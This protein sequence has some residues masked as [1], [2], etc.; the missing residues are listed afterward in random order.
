MYFNMFM[1]NRLAKLNHC[2]CVGFLSFFLGGYLFIKWVLRKCSEW[3]AWLFLSFCPLLLDL[4]IHFTYAFVLLAEPSA[5]W[6]AEAALALQNCNMHSLTTYAS[7]RPWRVRAKAPNARMPIGTLCLSL[8]TTK[9][10]I[11][12]LLRLIYKCEDFSGH[13]IFLLQ[14]RRLCWIFASAL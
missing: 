4:S 6:W 3:E 10:P 13:P 2:N 9:T 5:Q 11:T 12:S 14:V 7:P 8:L 1:G